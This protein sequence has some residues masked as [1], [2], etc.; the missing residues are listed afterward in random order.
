MP[1][2][3]LDEN[4]FNVIYL[5]REIKM[6]E[7][8]QAVELSEV[9][10]ENIQRINN[11]KETLYKEYFSD[12]VEESIEFEFLVKEYIEKIKKHIKKS[13][14]ETVEKDKFPFVILWSIV[15]AQDTDDNEMHKFFICPPYLRNNDVDLDCVSMM[16]P[17][18][19]ALLL[20]NTGQEIT[21]NVPQGTL[22]YKIKRIII[23]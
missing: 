14:K 8:V 18:G 20:K 4:P 12:N 21:V 22:N 9:L 3:I 16:S 10:A 7:G 15:E 19:R 23:P 6:S 1:C 2:R 5:L 17:L 11:A 13:S